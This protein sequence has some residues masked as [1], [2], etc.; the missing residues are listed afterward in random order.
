MNLAL[1]KTEIDTQLKDPEIAATLV[2]TT[3]KGLQPVTMRQ[4]MLEGMIRGFEFKDFLEKNVYAIPFGGGYSLVTSIDYSRKIGMRSGVIGVAAPV[5][6]DTPDGK[7]LSC[8]ITVKKRVGND[9]GE[10]TAT[11]YFSEYNT[12]KQ[13]WASKPRT[14]IAKVAEMHALR[15]AC[16][17][18]LSQAYIQEETENEKIIQVDEEDFT[19]AETKLRSSKSLEELKSN[20]SNIS[21]KAKKQLEG[22]KDEVKEKVTPIE[23][24]A[25]IVEPKKKGSG[26]GITVPVEI[27]PE[28][29]AEQLKT[30]RPIDSSDIPA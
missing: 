21:P 14:M 4:A 24:Q 6:E 27:T 23:V 11:V 7:I 15:K 16:P 13:Q 2:L 17:E 28:E 10:F 3:F 29:A 30:M 5:Y 26:I 9:V 25:T 1:I 8:S 12:G 19:E 20:W 22:V 18:E